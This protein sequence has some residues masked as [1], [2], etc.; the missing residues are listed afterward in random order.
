VGQELPTLPEHMSSPLVLS[1]VHITRT[2]VNCVCFVDRCLSF[3]TFSLCH[4][5][6]C[7]SSIY[8]FWLPLWYLQALLTIIK[9][10][11]DNKLSNETHQQYTIIYFV[12]QIMKRYQHSE[13]PTTSHQLNALNTKRPRLITLEIQ[14]LVYD[15]HNNVVGLN[16]LKWDPKPPH[17]LLNFQRQYRYRQNIKI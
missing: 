6:V 17:W 1:W 2:L 16:R 13:K 4:C 11:Q 8:E 3:C 7:S 10:I 12:F 5:V 15:R 9:L 14:V